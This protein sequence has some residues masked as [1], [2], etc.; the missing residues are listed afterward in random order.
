[1]GP[2]GFIIPGPHAAVAVHANVGGAG[3][4]EDPPAGADAVKSFPRSPGHVISVKIV[5][6]VMAD[7]DAVHI[8]V[9]GGI[10]SGAVFNAVDLVVEKK[11]GNFLRIHCGK[12]F[13]K[14][15][16]IIHAFVGIKDGRFVH[17]VPETVNSR[18][19]ENFIFGTKPLAGLCV[20]HIR[21]MGAP[22]PYCGGK[23]A[24]V[25][26][27]AEISAGLSL[28]INGISVLNFYTGVDNRDKMDLAGFHVLY[29]SLKVRKV[30]G[31]YCKVFVIF[32]VVNVHIDHI[33]GNVAAAVSFHYVF[34]IF[35]CFISPAALT[36][37]KGK[38]WRY[39]TA[40]YDFAKLADDIQ[41]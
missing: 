30:L 5:D 26:P 2:P 35:F 11:L 33:Q 21:E 1:M 41:S 3:K 40:P 12:I 29:K 17:I 6:F 22:R 19:S 38:F 20:Q 8:M 4:H 9:K 39:I 34:K 14:C 27:L 25:L 23:I 28:F 16:K 37:A 36:K 31:I 10:I 13:Q 32:H 15:L 24:A 7:F 18:V